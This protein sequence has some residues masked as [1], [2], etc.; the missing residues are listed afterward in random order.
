MTIGVGALLHYRSCERGDQNEL[1]AYLR[2]VRDLLA[3]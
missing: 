3:P 2:E 1:A